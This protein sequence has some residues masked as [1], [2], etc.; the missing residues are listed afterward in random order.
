[1]VGESMAMTD[2]RRD[3]VGGG[4]CRSRVVMVWG[5]GSVSVLSVVMGASQVFARNSATTTGRTMTNQI[6]SCIFSLRD[7]HVQ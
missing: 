6:I 1:M 5:M 2:C 4:D 3:A 7:R